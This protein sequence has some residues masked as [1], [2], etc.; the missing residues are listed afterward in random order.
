MLELVADTDGY[1]TVPSVKDLDRAFTVA[2]ADKSGNIDIFEFIRIYQL[3]KSNAVAGMAN[4]VDVVIQFTESLTK[5][6]DGFK[7]GDAVYWKGSDA[8]LPKGTEG[9]VLCLHGD[10]DAEVLFA[11]KVYTFSTDRLV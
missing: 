7:P 3:I 8:D 9:K 1:L 11:K 6:I 10:G 2:D 5:E 4:N